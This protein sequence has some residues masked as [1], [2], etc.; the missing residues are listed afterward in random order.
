M[1]PAEPQAP[2]DDHARRQARLV[3]ARIHA[4]GA[5]DSNSC[6]LNVHAKPA[7]DTSSPANRQ[8]AVSPTGKRGG[9]RPTGT[10]GKCRGAD[11]PR[12]SPPGSQAADPA[13]HQ[14]ASTNNAR[15]DI[16]ADGGPK[17][18]FRNMRRMAGVPSAQVSPSQERAALGPSSWAR[19]ARRQLASA[20]SGSKG[21][22]QGPRKH[23]AGRDSR[24]TGKLC[25]P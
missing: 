17:S 24:A 11:E 10:R 9:A 19:K 16:A 21:A 3:T 14:I 2:A 1:N 13:Y 7:L 20:A 23:G 8:A 22:L 25:G 18:R 6:L 12:P 4:E 5:K 15:P